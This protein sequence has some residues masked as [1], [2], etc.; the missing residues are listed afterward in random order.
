MTRRRCV[1]PRAARAGRRARCRVRRA[2]RRRADVGRPRRI[3]RP[4]VVTVASCDSGNVGTVSIPGASFAHALHQAGI[5]LVVAS[6]FPLSKEGSVPL[7]GDVV[8]GPALGRASAGPAAALRA[9]LHA[10]YTS[11]WHDWASLV[12]YEA[13]PQALGDQLDALRYRQSQTRD[14]CRARTHRPRRGA[15]RRR[16]LPRGIARRA[17][18]GHRARCRA[19]AARAASTRSNAWGC[20]PA[21]ASGSRRRR[22]CSRHASRVTRTSDGAIP[23]T[24]WS[25]H[26]S[27][28]T[29]RYVGLLVNDGT[30]GAARRDAALGARA[31]R[32][33][34]RRAG[35]R[36]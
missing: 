27:T 25:R 7:A 33:A 19:A 21:R 13:L 20:A 4:A 26:G 32:V 35:Q 34:V 3:H 14:G 5:P 1:R 17:R 18:P 8:R 15:G 10:R 31:G 2:L 24:C 12:V 29:R 36:R 16:A 23:T 28:T 11:T 9:E 22:S 30:R 6:Q